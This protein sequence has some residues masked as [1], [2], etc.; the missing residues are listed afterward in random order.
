M[1]EQ[2]TPQGTPEPGE[3]DAVAPAETEPN[4]PEED[5]EHFVGVERSDATEDQPETEALL[6]EESVRVRR[7]PRYWRFMLTGAVVFAIVVFIVTYSLPQGSG[8]DRNTVFGFMLLVGVA[9]G[10]T[11]GAVAALLA[12][13]VT[14]RG[15]TVVADRVDVR[16]VTVPDAAADDEPKN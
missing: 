4:G 7:S 1:A 11:L 2:Q 8:Y 10:I 13:R 9:V 3:P 6:Y 12:D 16:V 5:L 15:R 14:R